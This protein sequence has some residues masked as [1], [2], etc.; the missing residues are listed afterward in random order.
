VKP[1]LSPAE[2]EARLPVWDAIA[3]LFPDT[4]IDAATL[5]RI[6]R[7][8]AALPFSVDELRDI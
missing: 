4:A 3:E 6:A 7:E 8:L 1:V 2:I 5:E